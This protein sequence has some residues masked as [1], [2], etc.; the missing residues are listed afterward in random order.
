[1]ISNILVL[2]KHVLK[3]VNVSKSEDVMH[4]YIT[5][6]FDYRCAGINKQAFSIIMS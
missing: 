3:S 2:N 5:N 1:M 6:T 4:K